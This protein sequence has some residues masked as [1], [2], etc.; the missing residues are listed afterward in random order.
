MIYLQAALDHHIVAI[1]GQFIP[2]RPLENIREDKIKDLD[3][4]GCMQCKS[5]DAHPFFNEKR[6]HIIADM[7]KQLS[8]NKTPTSCAK[9]ARPQ[10]ASIYGKKAGLL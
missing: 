1:E 6:D 8:I 2:R 10:R 9:T 4:L 3:D 5:C 7:A